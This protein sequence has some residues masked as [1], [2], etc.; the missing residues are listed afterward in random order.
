MTGG[1]HSR[2]RVQ[3]LQRRPVFGGGALGA[4]DVVAVG[5]VDGDHVGD[6]DDALL[7]ALQVVA[8]AGEQQHE[9]EIDHVGDGD[10]RLADA[11]RLDDDDVEA[12]RLAQRHR[13]AR[14]ARD[15]A[16]RARRWAT[17]G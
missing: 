4:R 9:E 12:G 5:L 3:D 1:D 2:R 16:E 17:G 11:D 7:D 10:L 15:A 8:A 6:L 13:L 14:L